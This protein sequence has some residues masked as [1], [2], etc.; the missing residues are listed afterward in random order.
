[1]P[2][3]SRG[4]DVAKGFGT[5]GVR[6]GRQIK[7]EWLKE[8]SNGPSGITMLVF[9]EY[10]KRFSAPVKKLFGDYYASF[11]GAFDEDKVI[12]RRRSATPVI[13]Y[14]ALVQRTHIVN[15][16]QGESGADFHGKIH[17]RTSHP[18]RSLNI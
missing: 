3:R 1:M 8:F 7:A 12:K 2:R 13:L 15:S 10:K 9:R 4:V 14:L 6:Q 18:L 5:G 16:L 11:T 17:P